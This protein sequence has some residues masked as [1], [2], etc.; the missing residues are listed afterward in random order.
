MKARPIA[1]PLPL[2]RETAPD[3]EQSHQA[4]QRGCSELLRVS[5][6]LESLLNLLDLQAGEH[7]RDSRLHALLTPLK[8][9]L[10][11]AL[12]RCRRCSGGCGV[13]PRPPTAGPCPAGD[14]GQLA[15]SVRQRRASDDTPD[16]D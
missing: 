15:H 8:Q 12:D 11:Q 2:D 14:P 7:A 5:A 1:I 9:Q 13:C 3:V 6:G 10:D 4:S 16:Q